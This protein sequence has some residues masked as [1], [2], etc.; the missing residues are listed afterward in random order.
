MEEHPDVSFSNSFERVMKEVGEQFSCLSKAHDN[1][2]RWAA[3]WN[4]YFTI[5]TIVLSGL[6]GLGAVGGQN[7]LPFENA[8]TFVGLISFVCATLQTV[9][10]YYSFASRSANHKNSSIQYAKLHQLISFEL[11]LPR[12]ERMGAEKIL[13]IIK[14]ESARLLETSPQL[15]SYSL[16]EFKKEYGQETGISI[17]FMLNGLKQIRIQNE[18]V[19]DTPINIDSKRPTIRVEV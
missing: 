16:A 14:D 9:S 19:P 4:S 6:S 13:I 15:P 17:P 7:L 12:A 8:T 1:A 2:S 18:I 3:S 10:S 11:S 5:P